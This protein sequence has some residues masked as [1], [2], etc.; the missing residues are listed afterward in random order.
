MLAGIKPCNIKTKRAQHAYMLYNTKDMLADS[1]T[2]AD[3]MRK[4]CLEDHHMMKSTQAE[5]NNKDETSNETHTIMQF[6]ESFSDVKQNPRKRSDCNLPDGSK[7]MQIK[8]DLFADSQR[9]GL[10][11]IIG[12]R[13]KGLIYMDG[14]VKSGATME[15]IYNQASKSLNR[16]LI[17]LAGTNDIKNK[18]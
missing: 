5:K 16:P 17:L 12:R 10:P 18:H 2:V 9:K 4:N 11:E 1:H 14:L 15:Q 13:S 8:V 7:K 3:M 6:E